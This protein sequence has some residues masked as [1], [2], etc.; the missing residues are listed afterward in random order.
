MCLVSSAIHVPR[1]PPPKRF[2]FRRGTEKTDNPP[3]LLTSSSPHPSFETKAPGVF[4]VYEDVHSRLLVRSV[5][6]STRS[7]GPTE[8]WAVPLLGH[9]ASERAGDMLGRRPGYHCT[10]FC[11]YSYYCS[12]HGNAMEDCAGLHCRH[13][14]QRGRR[15]SQR[16]VCKVTRWDKQSESFNWIK[17][18]YLL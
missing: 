16:W 11:Y 8:R 14:C 10:E 17:Y 6:R 3:L 2:L 15:R 7:H 1:F 12:N 4:S 18:I 5:L 9:G 13:G